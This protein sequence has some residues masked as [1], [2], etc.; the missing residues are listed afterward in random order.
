M[1]Q[2]E[3]DNSGVTFSATVVDDETGEELV[4]G[5]GWDSAQEVLDFYRRLARAVAVTI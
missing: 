3:K 1:I 2:I 4:F 5:D